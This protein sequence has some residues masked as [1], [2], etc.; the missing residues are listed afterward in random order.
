MFLAL[1]QMKHWSIL[2]SLASGLHCCS[3]RYLE[4]SGPRCQGKKRTKRSWQKQSRLTHI[5]GFMFGRAE[6][7]HLCKE[8]LFHLPQPLL[9]LVRF[10]SRAGSSLSLLPCSLGNLLLPPG[11]SSDGPLKLLPET[12]FDLVV[13]DECAQALEASCWIPLLKAPK[14]ILAGDHKQLPP[15]IISNR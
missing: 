4:A 13:I 6:F 5:N 3:Q 2:L 1:L 10:V 9:Q 8:T 11:A 12:H 14:C 15:T 7:L